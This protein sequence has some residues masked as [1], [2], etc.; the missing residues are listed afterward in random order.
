MTKISKLTA[1]HLDT[2]KVDPISQG[3]HE[4]LVPFIRKS[5]DYP[6]KAH[7]LSI[8]QDGKVVAIGGL[9]LLWPGVAE[10]WIALGDVNWGKKHA[11]RLIIACKDIILRMAHASQSRR[12]QCYVSAESLVSQKFVESL[13]FQKEAYLTRFAVDGTDRLLY[14]LFPEGIE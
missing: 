7:S 13:G 8:E 12:V 9:V 11:K 10:A 3:Y 5:L 14:V 4:A 1:E 2:F 6:D